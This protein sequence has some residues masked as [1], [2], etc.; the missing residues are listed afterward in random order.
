MH[1]ER[2]WSLFHRRVRLRLAWFWIPGDINVG[3]RL[4]SRGSKYSRQLLP[5]EQEFGLQVECGYFSGIV[6]LV[7]ESA[8]SLR[9][10]GQEAIGAFAV[11]GF[12]GE[13]R[14]VVGF[15]AIP[16]VDAAI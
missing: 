11:S 15:E 10:R 3:I 1:G 4:W 7:L 2:G 8:E 12:R 5:Y 16:N 9:V 6:K 14:D 13:A